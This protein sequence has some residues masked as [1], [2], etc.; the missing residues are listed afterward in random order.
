MV[1]PEGGFYSTQDADSEGEEGKFF[2]WTL[3]EIA[4]ALPPEDTELFIKYY[5]VTQEGN[6]EGKNILHVAQDAQTAATAAEISLEELQ[7]SL[8][9]R[10]ERLFKVRDKRIKPGPH[11]QILP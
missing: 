4:A 11:T 7:A 5:G 8:P 3:A 2:T 10:R 1:L 6:F 9:L